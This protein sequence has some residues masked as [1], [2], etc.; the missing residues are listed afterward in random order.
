LE[1]QDDHFVKVR[2][3]IKDVIQM[4][5]G[6][7]TDEATSK[8]FCD[9]E[10]NEAIATRDKEAATMEESLA[11]ASSEEA[12]KEQLTKEIAFLTQDIADMKQTLVKAAELREEE[13]KNH[14]ETI[15]GAEAGLKAV[16]DA[17]QI[18]NKVYGFAQLDRKPEKADRDGNLVQSLAP[19]TSFSGDYTGNDGGK[20]VIGLLE[21][22]E[23]DF[24]RTKMTVGAAEAKAE[25][26]YSTLKSTTEGD[27][28]TKEASV[29]SKEGEIVIAGQ[30]IV[31]AQDAWKTASDLKDGAMKELE[32]LQPMCVGA[33]SDESYA[34]RK[35]K[36]EQEIEAL[37]RAL[38][39]LEDYRS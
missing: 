35:E 22:I 31:T 13:K 16:Q 9:K 37:R 27:I 4:L 3:L 23:A 8:S 12:K 7:A 36:R 18:L 14:A 21:V 1:L 34:E 30:A 20:G 39:V 33:D 28:S 32:K 26:D 10:V 25:Q 38:Q 2:S 15:A 29:T 5:E 6:Q 11:T 19:K 17:I 24:E